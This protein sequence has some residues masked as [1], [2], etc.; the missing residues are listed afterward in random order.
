VIDSPVNPVTEKQEKISP[1]H[2]EGSKQCEDPNDRKLQAA[3]EICWDSSRTISQLQHH[4]F[5]KAKISD[6]KSTGV[7][8]ITFK[9][10]YL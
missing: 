9:I 4:S 3:A 2:S 1:V 5:S 8:E 7:Q 6:S 10:P